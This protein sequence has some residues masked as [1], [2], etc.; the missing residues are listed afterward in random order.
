MRALGRCAERFAGGS[1]TAVRYGLGIDV[2]LFDLIIYECLIRFRCKASG[3]LQTACKRQKRLVGVGGW[4]LRRIATEPRECPLQHRAGTALIGIGYWRER[5]AEFLSRDLFPERLEHIVLLD[6]DAGF[7][8][9]T[10]GE[11]RVYESPGDML[12]ANVSQEFCTV[13]VSIH[14]CN[15]RAIVVIGP[16][17]HKCFVACSSLPARALSTRLLLKRD[18]DA[19]S[20]V[21]ATPTAQPPHV[22]VRN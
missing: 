8:R 21:A 6:S 11:T 7:A 20:L 1:S 22:H 3:C 2:W 18:R 17:C 14:I 12:I 19:R 13:C 16:T 5:H 10:K 9:A 15:T 4:Q